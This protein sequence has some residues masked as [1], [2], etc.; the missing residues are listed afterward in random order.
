[1]KW[2]FKDGADII[3]AKRER[4]FAITLSDS[5]IMNLKNGHFERPFEKLRVTSQI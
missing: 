5:R 3:D 2:T 1:M 4:E